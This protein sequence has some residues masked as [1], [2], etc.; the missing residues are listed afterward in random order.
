MERVVEMLKSFEKGSKAVA[1]AGD[2]MVRKSSCR[3]AGEGQNH[4]REGGG[5]AS[6]GPDGGNHKM[7]S[8]SLILLRAAGGGDSPLKGDCRQ[9]INQTHS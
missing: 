4:L 2:E 5:E 3:T 7:V 1:T 6:V 8:M 9:G